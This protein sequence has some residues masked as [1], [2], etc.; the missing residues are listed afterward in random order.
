MDDFLDAYHVLGV[1]SDATQEALKAAHRRLV[2]RHHPDLLPEER[3]DAADRRVR[4]INVAYGLVRDPEARYRYDRVRRLQMAHRAADRVRERVDE[5]A[6]A[7]QWETLSR[8]A[9][10]WAGRWM[11][12]R[13]ALSYRAGRTLGRWLN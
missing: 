2:R 10:V 12:R 8:A 3:R 5:G 4:E 9:G 6:L 11:Q 1:P 13:V 7:A